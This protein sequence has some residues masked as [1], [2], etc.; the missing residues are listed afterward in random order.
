MRINSSSRSVATC[1]FVFITI[2]FLLS[3]MHSCKEKENLLPDCDISLPANGTVF[4]IGDDIEIKAQSTDQDGNI[5]SVAFYFN[6]NEIIKA[7]ASPYQCIV[8]TETMSPGEYEIRAVATDDRQGMATDKITVSLEAPVELPEAAFSAS[9]LVGDAPLTV[10]FSES[11]SGEPET[12]YW[13]FGDGEEENIRNPEHTFETPG[14]YS[15]SLIVENSAGIDT[16]SKSDYITVT[17]AVVAPEA[18]FSAVPLEGAAPLSVAFTDS[19]THS[20][21]SWLWDFGDGTTANERNPV[22]EYQTP[23]IYTVSLLAGNEAGSD[24]LTKQGYISVYQD[25]VPPEA[26]FSATPLSGYAPLQVAFSD[27]SVNDVD[28]WLWS[29]GDGATAIETNPVHIFEDPG[30]YTVTLTVSNAA[31]ED[32][33][34]KQEY[35][36]VLAVPVPP[37]TNFTGSPSFGDPP[38]Q[39]TFTDLSVNIPETWEWNFGDGGVSTEQNP[40]YTYN[41]PGQYNVSLITS[42]IA[43]TDTL[44]KQSYIFVNNNVFPP[45]SNFSANPTLGYRPLEVTFTD[46]SL[47]DPASWLWDFGDGYTSDEQNPVHTYVRIGD[48]T[49]SLTVTNSEGSDVMTKEYYIQV[50]NPVQ[51]PDAAFTAEPTFGESPLQVFFTDESTNVPTSWYWDFGDGNTTTAHSPVH[52]YTD[53]GV[54]TVSLTATNEAGSDTE[55]KE[56]FIEVVLPATCPE[57]MTDIDGNVYDAL[58]IGSQCWMQQNLKVTHYPNGDEIPHVVFDDDWAALENNNT[59]DARCYVGND[60]DSDYGMMYS[61]AAAIADNWERD[62]FDGQGVCPDGWRLPTHEEWTELI[63]FLGGEET[64]GAELKE[65]G[66]EHWQYPNTGATN[67][68]FFTALPG[69]FRS[70][71]EGEFER[72]T[73][74]AWFWTSQEYLNGL[75][76]GR[77][78]Q[79]NSKEASLVAPAKSK[80]LTIRCILD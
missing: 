65:T 5:E 64:A 12:W 9:P 80:G 26:G 78:M 74:E 47:N 1:L 51:V 48:F 45:Q 61:F 11:S 41:V 27:E 17:E 10:V 35:I 16:L 60:P 76:Y 6:N 14:V 56:D 57:T 33:V 46:L 8:S 50:T 13:I 31:G 77:I 4:L 21:E 49:V 15:V 42:N 3:G 58:E 63:E 38:L 40:V 70:Q 19:S 62:N 53:P 29:F 24:V 75:V 34:V 22:H 73:E 43:G 36:S 39:V 7:T 54:Y 68:S 32:V 30:T 72:K 44:V 37:Q 23:G 2:V 25:I 59:D 20:P 66:T 67:S 52:I 71:E 55:T 28:T 79:Y 18:G 69:G